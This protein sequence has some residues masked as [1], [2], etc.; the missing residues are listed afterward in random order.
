[1]TSCGVHWLKTL[2]ELSRSHDFLGPLTF[3]EV[4]QQHGG[5]LGHVWFLLSGEKS[6][7]ALSR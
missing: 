1:M 5:V 6:V 4:A 2:R 3:V 7:L